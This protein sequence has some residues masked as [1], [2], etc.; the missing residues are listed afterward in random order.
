MPVTARSKSAAFA[1]GKNHEFGKVFVPA[2]KEVQLLFI[3][4]MTAV[5]QTCSLPWDGRS[6]AQS[7]GKGASDEK[8]QSSKRTWFR[9]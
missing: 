8:N 4:V 1:F 5:F 3:L 9:Q 6:E 7:A 2:A